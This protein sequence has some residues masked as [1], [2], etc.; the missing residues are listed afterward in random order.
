MRVVLPTYFAPDSPI[1]A[2]LP[3]LTPEPGATPT[4]AVLTGVERRDGQGGSERGHSGA[5]GNEDGAAD[6]CARLGL[7]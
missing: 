4:P 7:E 1:V 5:G 6:V 3:R 2:S